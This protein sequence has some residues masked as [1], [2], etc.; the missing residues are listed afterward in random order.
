MEYVRSFIQSKLGIKES[1]CIIRYF[2]AIIISSVVT[3]LSYFYY[4]AFSPVLSLMTSEF[5]FSEAERDLYLGMLF[6]CEV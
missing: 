5:G 6:A 3:T 4:N 2:P 1:A